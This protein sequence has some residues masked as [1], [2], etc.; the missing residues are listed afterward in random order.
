MFWNEP[1]N[2]S[3]WDFVELDPE[4][5]IFSDMVRLAAAAVAGEGPGLT[6]VLRGI[7][8]IDPAFI[9]RMQAQG[10]LDCVDAIAVHGFPLDWNHWNINEWPAKIAEIQAVTS[11]PVWVSEVGVSTFEKGLAELGAWLE[12][13]RTEDRSEAAD[14]ELRRRGLVA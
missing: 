14:R 10:V 7:S 3:H 9:R 2:K 5:R 11:L 6:R 13:Q 8:P 12:E 1:N 4:W